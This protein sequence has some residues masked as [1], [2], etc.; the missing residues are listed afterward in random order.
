LAASSSWWRPT[1]PQLALAVHPGRSAWR[2]L[3]RPHPGLAG[4][5]A[6]RRVGPCGPALDLF[7]IVHLVDAPA[8]PKLA[9]WWTEL[10]LGIAELVL[11]VWAIRSWERSLLT[12]GDD[13][14][15]V[16]NFQGLSEIVAAF[17]LRQGSKQVERPIS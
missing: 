13:G 8:G 12:L 3:R 16:G 14:R 11:G 17:S 1:G 10:L 7:G 2:G 5:H 6:V 9:W 4:N 15:G